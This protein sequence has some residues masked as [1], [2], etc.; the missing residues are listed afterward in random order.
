MSQIF[1]SWSTISEVS[2][3]VENDF[4]IKSYQENQEKLF[5]SQI[6]ELEIQNHHS[7]L[8]MNLSDK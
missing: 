5:I 4:S 3:N 7:F 1:F 2:D 6:M 8:Q